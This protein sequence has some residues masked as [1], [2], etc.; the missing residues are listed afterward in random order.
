M[1]NTT[2]KYQCRVAST[3]RT[4]ML[5][6]PTI[7]KNSRILHTL[8]TTGTT[9]N[10]RHERLSNP[11]CRQP[12][13]VRMAINCRSHRYTSEN[14]NVCVFTRPR[15]I[16]DHLRAS[17][18]IVVNLDDRDCHQTKKTVHDDSKLIFVVTSMG[19]RR[20]GLSKTTLENIY[21]PPCH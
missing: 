4:M 11:L 16:W 19:H 10:Y 21:D 2:I 1:S 5:S 6:T 14:V 17:S 3:S 12:Q 8:L 9:L 18:D 15:T 13:L 20:Y 7:W